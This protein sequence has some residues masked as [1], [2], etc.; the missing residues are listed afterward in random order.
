MKK[1]RRLPR[2]SQEA[3]QDRVDFRWLNVSEWG[4]ILLDLLPD[5]ITSDLID[6]LKQYLENPETYVSATWVDQGLKALG[7]RVIGSTEDML[8]DRLHHAFG[9]V[10]TFHSGRPRSVNSYFLNGI[11]IP[12]HDSLRS[13]A[14]QTLIQAP[15]MDSDM[16]QHG[17]QAMEE[18]LDGRAGELYLC[19]DHR[20]L[21]EKASHYLMR[22]SEYVQC[23]ASRIRQRYGVPR[24]CY[25][26]EVGTPT[27]IEVRIPFDRLRTYQR[28]AIA[29]DA[30]EGLGVWLFEHDP[31][32]FVPRHSL[33][34]RTPIPPDWVT[35]HF[36]V[37]KIPNAL[38]CRGTVRLFGG[39]C[40]VCGWSRKQPVTWRKCTA[41]V[42][43][44]VTRIGYEAR[45]N[46]DE[47]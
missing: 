7:R 17:I 11:Q 35:D 6:W 15:G 44:G 39:P 26:E 9:H 31:V 28:L 10:V 37:E 12:T 36:H 2:F 18:P 45:G 34:F 30:L 3:F 27:M 8:A 38:T 5:R 42:S 21:S 33:M 46:T 25:L 22:G 32:P 14:H 16:I 43:R 47:S 19:L 1:R 29:R 23:V 41:G 13:M 4:P 20:E 24:E 40:D